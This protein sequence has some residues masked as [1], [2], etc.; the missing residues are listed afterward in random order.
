MP[1]PLP[2]PSY[3]SPMPPDYYSTLGVS[4]DAGADDIRTAYR[5]LAR[6]YHPD[7]NKS[8]DAEERFAEI[9]E[10]YEVLND[11]E[12]RRAYDRFGR[13][14]V[15]A[16][17]GGYARGAA[18][19]TGPGG[20]GGPGG[21]GYNVDMSDVGSIF[22]EMFGG[23]G[24]SPFAGAHGQRSAPRRGANVEHEVTVTFMTAALGGREQVRIA[25]GDTP[26]TVSVRIPAGIESG[27]KLRIRGS[28]APGAHNGPA[29]DLILKVRVG[30]H[31]WFR[32]EGRDV[33]IDVPITV[34]EAGLGTTVQVP[35]LK[36]SAE[37]TI[38]PG[39]SSGRKLRVR[40]KGVE[41]D[42]GAAGDFYAVI[43]IIGPEKLTDTG[44]EHLRALAAELRNP[45][46]SGPW[47][48]DEAAS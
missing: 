8:E 22:E 1:L 25:M 16:G 31:P 41:V 5:K 32:R 11:P 42:D 37:I 47:A 35:L 45:R 7:V 2:L 12:K 20:P 29:G 36:G 13:A 26:S 40:G 24:G 6:T 4:R 21:V 19:P 27:A 15:K 33:L 48:S 17:P 10:A 23:R 18:G 46:D 28:G 43:Q 44:R 30:A 34:A 9:S 3:P 14:G 39:V 38:P